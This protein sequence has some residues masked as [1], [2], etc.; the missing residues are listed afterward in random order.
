MNLN[1]VTV[2]ALNVAASVDFY[3]RLRLELIPNNTDDRLPACCRRAD[4]G[5]T[6]AIAHRQAAV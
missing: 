2:P 1:Q 4:R 6:E 3:C 5:R